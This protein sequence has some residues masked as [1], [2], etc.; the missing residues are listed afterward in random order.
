M[1]GDVDVV[2]DG[3]R[4]PAQRPVGHVDPRPGA[5]RVGVDPADP[6]RRIA[7]RRDARRS[8]RRSTSSGCT[9]TGAIGVEHPGDGPRLA[10]DRHVG[11]SDSD[12]HAFKDA[13]SA[14]DD[15]TAPNTPPCIVTIFS[16]AW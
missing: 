11:A 5:D 12:G 3:E 1:P 10:G 2:L 7:V 15:A 8:S 9:S 16:A 4:D 14:S 6:D 13:R